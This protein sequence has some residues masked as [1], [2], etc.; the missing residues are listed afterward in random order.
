MNREEALRA[1]QELARSPAAKW[2]GNQFLDGGK[3][4]LQKCMRCGEEQTMELPAGVRSPADVPAGLD[5]K[6]FTWK[7]SFQIA[8]EGCVEEEDGGRAA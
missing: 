6:L 8:H 1:I 4:L 7:R 3:R 5:E 2:I